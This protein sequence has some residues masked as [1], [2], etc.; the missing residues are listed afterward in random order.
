MVALHHSFITTNSEYLDSL[1]YRLHQQFCCMM[2]LPNKNCAMCD[3]EVRNLGG[4]LRQEI[5]LFDV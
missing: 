5:V 2:R 4:G 3:A 1:A